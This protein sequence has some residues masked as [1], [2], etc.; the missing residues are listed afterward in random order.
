M[1]HLEIHACYLLPSL[2]GFFALKDK[3][4]RYPTKRIIICRLQQGSWFCSVEIISAA[5]MS[6]FLWL[7]KFVHAP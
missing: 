6:L 2:M 5:N 3:F 7:C 4:F 1:R